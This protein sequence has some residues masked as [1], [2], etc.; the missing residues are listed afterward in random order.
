MLLF[1]DKKIVLF[2]PLLSAIVYSSYTFE[3]GDSCEELCLWILVYS[4]YVGLRIL[5]RDNTL[6]KM[7]FIFVGF[8]G[9]VILWIKY[10]MLGFY[11]GWII[12]IFLFL[13]LDKNIGSSC[14]RLNNYCDDYP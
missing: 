1:A 9:A 4:L 11:F 6:T 2:I 8:L 13:W 7:H 10:L 14:H 3:R 12:T 5:M